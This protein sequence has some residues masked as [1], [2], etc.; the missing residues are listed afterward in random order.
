M[1]SNFE[2]IHLK[3]KTANS[4]NFAAPLNRHF[5]CSVFCCCPH[6]LW[7]G[8]IDDV[9]GNVYILAECLWAH[10]LPSPGRCS[11]AAGARMFLPVQYWCCAQCCAK[12]HYSSIF[13]RSETPSAI[14][15]CRRVWVV[16][17]IHSLWEDGLRAKRLAWKSA[18]KPLPVCRDQGIWKWTT[19][20]LIAG[21]LRYKWEQD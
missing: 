5:Q 4:M 20:E 9:N 8:W 15:H 11:I 2:L 3:I 13:L 19:S 1:G 17:G 6:A 18:C 21:L 16:V 7:E 10:R 12:C 14:G